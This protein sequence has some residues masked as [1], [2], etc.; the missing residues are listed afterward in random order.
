MSDAARLASKSFSNKPAGVSYNRFIPSTSDISA[1]SSTMNDALVGSAYAAALSYAEA[2]S[3][4]Q[5]GSISWSIVRL[6]Y[7]CFY[8]LRA[9]LILNNVIPFNCGGEM[10]LDIKN[11]S[12][13]KGGKSSHHWNWGTLR[14]I[15]CMNKC[16]FLSSD[17]QEAYEKLREHRENVNYTHGFTDPNFHRCL[18]SGESDLGKRFRAYRDDDKFIYT[19]LADHLAI[20]YPTMLL[21]DLEKSMRKSSIKLSTENIDYLNKVWSIKDKCPIC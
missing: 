8:S 6:Y 11:N 3:G 5:K 19:Y 12:F 15:P 2:I 14:K 1:I 17:S 18:I 10:L 20:A 21:L 16:W 9:M 4:L 13:L 7:S